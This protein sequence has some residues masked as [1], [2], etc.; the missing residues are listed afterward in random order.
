M[1][2]SL[3]G[4]IPAGLAPRILG[5]VSLARA[6]GFRLG[7]GESLDALAMAAGPAPSSLPVMRA[8]LKSLLCGSAGDWRRFDELFDAYWLRRG[9]R[10]G[11]VQRGAGQAKS[12][13]GAEQ[14][15]RRPDRAANPDASSAGDGRRRGGASGTEL[16]ARTDLRHL[17][18]PDELVAVNALAERLARR[19]R[20]HVT[21]RM[22]VRARGRRIDMRTTIHRSLRTGGMP[23]DL[24]FRRRRERPI[25]LVA[26]LDASGSMS[27]YSAFFMR[28]IRGI[29][30]NFAEAEAFVFHT[31]LVH[32]SEVLRERDL[33]KAVDRMNVISAGWGGG[34]RLGACLA[35]FNRHYAKT[36]L[37]SRTVV[38]IFSDG[39]DTGDP[40]A[41]GEQLQALQRRA[42][43]IIWL[44]PLLGWPGYEPVAQ[45]MA[46][47]MPHIDLFAPAHNLESLAALEPALC[48]L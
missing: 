35:T 13:A 22:R 34:T 24:A 27:L 3:A 12:G 7:M 9:M 2:R 20:K 43:R 36:V 46:A 10:Q 38:M 48:G 1:R 28:F 6:N 30:E 19:M 18:D 40:A 29:V 8:S 45:G 37:D 44:N 31:R 39:Y 25:R 16:L 14:M 42:R 47:A 15:A 11:A 23:V 17:K 4:L 26:M 32:V 5:F 21:R 41:L 33:E